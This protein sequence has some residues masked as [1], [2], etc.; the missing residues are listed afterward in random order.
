MKGKTRVLTALNQILMLEL[1][2]INQFFL[3]AR[4]FKNWALQ[5]LDEKAYKK[6]I[7]DMKQADKIIERIL[8]LEGLPNLQQLGRLRIGEHTAEMLEC[9]L[10][11]E[12]E[13]VAALRA[14]IALCESEEDYVSR[15]LLEKILIVEEDHIDWIEAQQYLIANTGIENYQQSMMES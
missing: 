7:K 3:H 4:M 15:D 2:S 10:D 13:Q 5:R 9:D 12:T 14:A 8:F 11:F 6:S 1:T